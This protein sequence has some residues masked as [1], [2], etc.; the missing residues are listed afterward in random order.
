[1]RFNFCGL[2]LNL[3]PIRF[4]TKIQFY[5]ELVMRSPGSINS[6]GSFPFKHGRLHEINLV[7]ALEISG[8]KSFSAN[9][10]FASGNFVTLATQKF[11]AIEFSYNGANYFEKTFREAHYYGSANNFQPAAYHRLDIGFNFRKQLKKGERNIYLG[12]YN[13][14]NRQNPYYYYFGKSNDERKLY[15]YSLFP[16]IPSFSYT[17][18]W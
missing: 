18:K 7:Y 10:I 8:N 12:I 14:Y 16:I 13:V 17:Y 6:G 2:N 4:L 9:W 3:N 15:Q 11:P 5:V 1:M